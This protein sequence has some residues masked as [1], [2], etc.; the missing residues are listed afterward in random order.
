[1][2]GLDRSQLADFV[3]MIERA[4]SA[5]PATLVRL[6]ADAGAGVIAGFVRLPFEVLAGRTI[7]TQVAADF[8]RTYEAAQLLQW[9]ENPAVELFSRDAGWLSPLPPRTGW[10]RVEVVPDSA[11]REV[12]RSGALLAASATSR[13]AQQALLDAIVLTARSDS[14]TVEVPLGPLSALTRMGYL[15][16]GGEAAV[17]V[18]PGWIRVAA[19]YGST[20]S[21]AASPLGLLI[22]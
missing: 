16:R 19:A 4:I 3:P 13:S 8:D 10:Q 14:R 6:R 15:P 7:A 17:D 12:V 21:S 1:M 11:I 2:T 18:V 5:D 9:L 22:G 20:Y